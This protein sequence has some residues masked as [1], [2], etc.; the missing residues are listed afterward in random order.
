MFPEK[1]RPI[2][3]RIEAETAHLN[4]LQLN[5]LFCYGAQQEI[6]GGIKKLVHDIKAGK[7]SE[8]DI[9]RE[10]FQNYL[11]TSG[12]PE[13]DLIVRTGGV[14]RLSNFLLYQAAYSEFYF[15]DCLWPDIT[16]E[17]LNGA[18][19]FFNESQRNAGT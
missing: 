10:V 16:N 13:P 12:I 14:K 1:V 7:L 17:H 6:I 18:L 5:F 3:E 9:S 8:D 4:K 11:W 2:C 15:L 19:N